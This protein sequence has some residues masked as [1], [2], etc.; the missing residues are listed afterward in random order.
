MTA[1][2][3]QLDEILGSVCDGKLGRAL[4]AMENYLFTYPHPSRQDEYNSIK[5]NYRLMV[6]YWRNGYDDPQRQELYQRLLQQ[7]YVLTASL[8]VRYSIRNTSYWMS[9]YQRSRAARQNW[10][11]TAVRKDLEDFVSEL[12]MTELVP[13]N[14][15]QERQRA[16]Y[17]SHQMLASNLF[18]YI[19]TS[20][21]WSE[22][23]ADAFRG[24]L[25]SPT[26]DSADQQLIVSAITLSLLNMFDIN[27]FMVLVD[28]YRQS[29]DIAV[30]QRAL[31]GWALGTDSRVGEVYPELVETLKSLMAD[32]T[33]CRDVIELQIQLVYCLQAEEDSKKIRDEVIPELIKNNRQFRFTRDGGLEEMEEDPMEDILHPEEAEQRMEKLEKTMNEMV[34]MQKAGSDIYYSGFSQIKRFPFFHNAS[35]WLVPYYRQHPDLD[36]AI[37]DPR[38][39]RIL[40]TLLKNSPFCDSDTYSFALAL[41]ATFDKYPPSVLAMF[42]RGEATLLGEMPVPEEWEKPAFLRRKY[43]QDLFRFFKLFSQRSVFASPFEKQND[44]QKAKFVMQPLFRQTV[45]VDD[46]TDLG[47]FFSKHKS[48]NDAL[49]LLSCVPE[50]S[51]DMRFYLLSASVLQQK[52][53]TSFEGILAAECYRKVLKE[54]PQNKRALK[55]YARI[56]FNEHD[57]SGALD[58]YERLLETDG[59]R[60][61][62]LLNKAVCL[63]NL[64]CYEEAL[65]ILFKINYE[66]PD[67]IVACRVL[68]WTLL[69]C[70]KSE[71]AARYYD[72]LLAEAQPEGEDLLNYGLCKWLQGDIAGAADLIRQY[73]ADCP[74]EFNTEQLFGSAEGRLLRK[75]GISD[76][77]IRMMTDLLG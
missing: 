69:G 13:E 54:D 51:R 52:N 15:R 12:A 32:D 66:N 65:K 42:E 21:Q 10:A 62:Y 20:R 5:E 31:V 71:Q 44:I 64:D 3:E 63:S 16:L 30:A 4:V 40:T 33:C 48:Y 14:Q 22:A 75:H 25:L 55:G 59:S 67:N 11:L 49:R 35:N 73:A 56:L 18:D 46:F 76:I 23:V 8:A 1:R 47:S 37:R 29:T 2:N 60:E 53:V 34:D 9:V 50:K 36:A 57:Y 41:A 6:D 70:G 24:I 77:E 45:L 43:L 17:R 26:I 19:W 58:L 61:G 27:K 38:C 74:R 39:A 68:A 72:Q 28:V 7:M